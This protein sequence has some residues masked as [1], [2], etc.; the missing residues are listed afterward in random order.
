[1][2]S[3]AGYILLGLVVIGLATVA[4]A[5]YAIAQETV[6]ATTITDIS[7]NPPPKNAKPG[8]MYD[9]A[10]TER[11]SLPSRS[12]FDD[13]SARVVKLEAETAS[14]KTQ[15]KTLQAANPPAPK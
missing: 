4:I 11:R 3:R 5:T 14:L 2:K 8:Q 7:G 12:E 10:P 6:P 15:V 1:M 9:I 13:L